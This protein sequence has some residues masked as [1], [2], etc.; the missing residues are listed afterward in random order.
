MKRTVCLLRAVIGLDG[1]VEIFKMVELD[2]EPC[3]GNKIRDHAIPMTD[4]E[5]ERGDRL[6]LEKLEILDVETSIFNAEPTTAVR[7]GPPVSGRASTDRLVIL[8]ATRGW[9]E[10]APSRPE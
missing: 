8:A 4:A 9:V 1:E 6:E 10:N 5:V 7:V 3:R 2:T